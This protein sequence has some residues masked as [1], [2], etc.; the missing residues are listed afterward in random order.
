[1]GRLRAAAEELRTPASIQ[2]CRLSGVLHLQHGRSRKS[3]V[4]GGDRRRRA[5]CEEGAGH[6]S[7]AVAVA[8]LANINLILFYGFDGTGYHFSRVLFGAD[9]ALVL[10][11]VAVVFFLAVFVDALARSGAGSEPLP[12]REAFATE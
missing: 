6:L 7:T 11:I 10:S 5:I 8:L 4:S 12:G 1:M 9:L 2:P 3:S